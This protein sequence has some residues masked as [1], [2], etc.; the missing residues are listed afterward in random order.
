MT[1]AGFADELMLGD[2]LNETDEP[3]VRCHQLRADLA[4]RQAAFLFR[5]PGVEG[6]DSPV[7]YG[8]PRLRAAFEDERQVLQRLLFPR[9]HVREDVAYRPG[10]G[11]TRHHQLYIRQTGVRLVER[12]P[13]LVQSFQKLS[14]I[15]ERLTLSAESNRSSE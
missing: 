10:T 3:A 13:R 15:H 5:H 11:D 12:H 6:V 9:G 4:H 14:S 1:E 8:V 7:L 2:G